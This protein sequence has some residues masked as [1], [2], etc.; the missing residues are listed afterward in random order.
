LPR[1]DL[2]LRARLVPAAQPE[3]GLPEL[4]GRSHLTY[5]PAAVIPRRRC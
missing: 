1:R 3:R 2:V 5:M 4:P